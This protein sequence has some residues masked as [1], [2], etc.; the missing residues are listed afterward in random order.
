MTRVPVAL[1]AGLFVACGGLDKVYVGSKSFSES[2]LLA[3]MIALR[4]ESKGIPVERVI[5]YRE[6]RVCLR[7]LQEGVLDVYPEYTG[8]LL[9][10]GGLP[11]TTDAEAAYEAARRI[12]QPLGLA[13]GPRLGVRNDYA[14]AVRRDV[15]LRRGLTEIGDLAKLDGPL[16]FA[17]DTEA[18]RRSGDGIP[19][20]ARRYGLTLGSVLRFPPEQR[21]AWFDALVE[22]RADAAE[23]YSTD[24]RVTE[25]GLVL[26]K[27]ALGFYP[28]YEAAA[29]ARQDT[30]ER[31]PKLEEVLK[32][33]AG[34]VDTDAM[35]DMVARVEG[36]GDDY[37]EVARAHLERV[38]LLPETE[39]ATVTRHELP[40]AIGTAD[41]VG[42]LPIQAARALREVM[43]VRRLRVSSTSDPAEAVRSGRSR[44]G[45]VGAAEFLVPSGRGFK[46]GE[47]IEAVGVV[48]SRLAHVLAPGGPR[49][50]PRKG[51]I[52]LGVEPV[53]GPSHRLA[54]LVANALGMTERLEIVAVDDAGSLLANG[55][56]DA[57][58]LMAELGHPRVLELLED[59]AVELRSFAPVSDPRL[60]LRYPMLRPARIPPH[61]YPGQEKT[62]ETVSSQVVLAAVV[63]PDDNPLGDSG[64]GIAGLTRDAP[65]RVPP[66]TA[67]QIAA[68]LRAPESVDPLLPASPGLRPTAPP[69]RARVVGDLAAAL[70]NI[71]AV[72]YIIAMVAFFIMRTP[73]QTDLED[74]PP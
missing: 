64:P 25:Y 66:H 30:F 8:T 67:S 21:S 73:Q 28:S 45:L 9:G 16:R 40:L 15:S 18:T 10:L 19:A 43:P 20:L 63:P 49:V 59:G 1:L 58:L 27:D 47:G 65:L 44:F 37:R 74:G 4:A 31:H 22:G 52:R 36:R 41:D 70:V 56:V 71:L 24:P 35:R 61:T 17:S 60:T 26:L 3:E 2:K 48:G 7:G 23:V 33:L 39:T 34:Q 42:Y 12:V 5:P 51:T 46:M 72:A 53:G 11:P 29:L 54:S 55:E 32:D 57:I 14:I 62:L 13:L 6:G 38:G 69:A 68:A 50:G